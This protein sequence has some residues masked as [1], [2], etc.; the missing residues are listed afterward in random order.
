VSLEPAVLAM[1]QGPVARL[2]FVLRLSFASGIVRVWEG[3]GTLVTNTAAGQEEWLGSGGMVGVSEANHASGFFAS[4]CQVT[5]SGVP[6]DQIDI[7]GRAMAQEEEIKGRRIFIGCQAL[8]HRWQP[9]GAYFAYWAGTMDKLVYDR[10]LGQESVT[11]NCETPFVRRRKPRYGFLTDEDQ[12]RLFPGDK[13][14]RF[15]SAA[16]EKQLTWPSY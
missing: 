15:A 16:A 3:V 13:G 2:A 10:S 6:D 9:L 8:D 12:Q 11:V 14:L 4:T 7:Y 1:L 5:L